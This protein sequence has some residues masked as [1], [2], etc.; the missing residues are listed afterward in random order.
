M[1]LE[2]SKTEDE[3][4]LAV[5]GVVLAHIAEEATMLIST[6]KAENTERSYESD[7]NA[8]TGWC[9]QFGLNPLPAS[10]Q[11][12]VLYLTDQKDKLKVSTLQRR[13]SSISQ[14]HR[15]AGY[16]P[17][18]T[19]EEPL[20]TL[21]QSIRK[22]K[23]TAQKGKAPILIDDIRLMLDTLEDSLIGRRD[24]ALLLLGFAG[25]FRRSELVGL[26]IEDLTF[27]RDGLTVHLRKSKTDQTGEGRLIGIPYGSNSET[28]PVR[29]LDD[30]IEGS[31]IQTGALFRPINKS[32]E[33][34]RERQDR[35]GR[36]FTERLSD[37]AVALI[38]KRAAKAAGLDETTFAGH[39]LRAGLATSAAIAGKS[40]ASIM[41]Q[42]GHR[43]ITMVRKYI[44]DGSLFRD[45][46]AASIGL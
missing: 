15:M 40:E 6:A 35:R 25:A 44:R 42:T 32:G 2:V 37:K 36:H 20:H 23:G 8:F 21:W 31:A 46:A 39:S 16:K 27:H 5:R 1:S 38:V 4:Q 17:I 3:T 41:K 12:L 11:T 18:S 14:A 26:D 22:H 28:C 24:R 33:I 34:L 19:R 45:N 30:W 29:A 13:I 10:T 9:K 43:S 7:W